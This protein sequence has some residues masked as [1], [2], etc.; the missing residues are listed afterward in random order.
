MKRRLNLKEGVFIPNEE[1]LENCM[2]GK[3]CEYGICDE[4]SVNRREEENEEK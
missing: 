2:K 1:E 3:A 4:C